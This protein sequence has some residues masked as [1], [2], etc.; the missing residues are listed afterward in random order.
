MQLL[1]G[2]SHLH[3]NFF[4]CFGQKKQREMLKIYNYTNNIRNYFAGFMMCLVYRREIE[5][6]KI[7]DNFFN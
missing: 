3:L 7:K 6:K 1:L 2:E 5:R 4:F